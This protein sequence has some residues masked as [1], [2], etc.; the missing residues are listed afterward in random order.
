MVV[1]IFIQAILIR[2]CKYCE[3][4]PFVYD[5]WT[6]RIIFVYIY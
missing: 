5:Y 2:I 6:S 3:R 1:E 4:I